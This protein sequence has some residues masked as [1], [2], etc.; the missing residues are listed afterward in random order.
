MWVYQVVID[1]YLDTTKS[2][3]GIISG[4]KG[5]TGLGG[6]DAFLKSLNLVNVVK[7]GKTA[8][9]SGEKAIKSSKENNES[10]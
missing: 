8:V 10:K 7:G 5:L 2:T 1:K 3:S 6:Q 4:G 9:D